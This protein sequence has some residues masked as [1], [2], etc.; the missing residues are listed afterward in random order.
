MRRG[1]GHSRLLN[2]TPSSRYRFEFWKLRSSLHPDISG[3]KAPRV[4]KKHGRGGM[5]KLRSRIPRGKAAMEDIYVK[6]CASQVLVCCFLFYVVLMLIFPLCISAKNPTGPLKP[7][8]SSI[9][10]C[11][12]KFVFQ[13]SSTG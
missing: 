6:N 8:K 13:G 11:G 7:S 2:L 12:T 4:W 1:G 5:A 10:H 3:Q 9:A